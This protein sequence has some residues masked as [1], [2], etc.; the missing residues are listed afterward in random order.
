MMK[1]SKQKECSEMMPKGRKG[2]PNAFKMDPKIEE[3]PYK[4]RCGKG[5][6]K[7]SEKHRKINALNLENHWFS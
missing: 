7:I 3:N 1:K 2:M 5:I 6:E 4:N